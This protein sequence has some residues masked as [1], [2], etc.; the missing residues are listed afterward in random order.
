ADKSADAP[1]RLE[2]LKELVNAMAEFESLTD[3][4]EHVALVMELNE[5]EDRDLVSIMTLHAAKGLEFETIFLPGWEQ[6]LFPNQRALDQEGL[7]GLEEERRLA[8]VGLTRARRE[9]ILSFAANRR[10]HGTW[11]PALPSK[12]IDE[13]PKE[14]IEFESDRGLYG[15][16]VSRM[17]T[18]SEAGF[19][20]SDETRWSP[21]RVRARNRRGQAD[22][23]YLQ[24]GARQGGAGAVATPEGG[25]PSRGSRIF[26]RKFGYGTVAA[27]EGDRLDI[28]FDKAGRKRVIASFVVLEDQAG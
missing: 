24:G 27:V 6:G 28:A 22:A 14:H 18:S 5:T 2:N 1:G 16:S 10:L 3:F 12:F 17:H 15:A 4:L 19:A 8:Y 25:A 26:H 11:T 7:R 23:P 21:G 9:V 13:I 20:E